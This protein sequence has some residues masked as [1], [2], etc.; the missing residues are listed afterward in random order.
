MTSKTRTTGTRRAKLTRGRAAVIAALALSLGLGATAQASAGGPRTVSGKQGDSFTRIADFYGAYMD[1]KFDPD[2]GSRL[3]TALR[4][5]YIDSAYLK[6]LKDWENTHQED[7]VLHAQN[8][9]AAWTVT[10]HGTATYSEAGITLFWGDGEKTKL[11]VDMNRR[12]HK[13]IHIGTTG[14]D[15]K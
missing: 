10:D 4:N 8:V 6:K 3:A 14:I 15:G 12:T 11:V 5:Y 13:I 7:G 1:A 9:P 2:H